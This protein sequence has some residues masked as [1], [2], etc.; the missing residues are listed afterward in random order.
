MRQQENGAEIYECPVCEAEFKEK[1]LLAIHI[2][3]KH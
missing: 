2:G 1:I 3:T